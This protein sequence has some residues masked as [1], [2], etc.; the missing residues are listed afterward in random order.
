MSLTRRSFIKKSS[1]SAAAVTVLGTGV[2]LAQT[3]SSGII[4]RMVCIEPP[5]AVITKREM[6]G[7]KKTFAEYF[8]DD[9]T[10]TSEGFISV[11]STTE[12]QP[13][14]DF[15][16]TISPVADPDTQYL[17][18][19]ILWE[20]SAVSGWKC[21]ISGGPNDQKV[22]DDAAEVT[23]T[24]AASVNEGT[25]DISFTHTP[26]EDDD[27]WGDS[28]LFTK[29]DAEPGGNAYEG[30]VRLTATVSHPFGLT[31]DYLFD[32]KFEK[33]VYAE[34]EEEEPE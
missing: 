6:C 14:V 15:T 30:L 10:A 1:Y 24:S 13:Y 9:T 7:S 31:G 20:I 21:W 33:A 25:G 18:C 16:A 12:I 34:P 22:D 4:W 29:L 28:Y 32:V 17:T 8:G 11:T 2:G 3:N 27:D 23:R 26:N 5:T 19:P